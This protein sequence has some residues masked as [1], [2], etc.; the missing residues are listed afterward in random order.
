[1]KHII[2]LSKGCLIWSQRVKT[3]NNTFKFALKNTLGPPL[4]C[5]HLIKRYVSKL[6]MK[7]IVIT[8]ALVLSTMEAHANDKE[9][10]LNL[11]CQDFSWSDVE[12]L[13]EPYLDGTLNTALVMQGQSSGY[14]TS[15]AASMAMD[16]SL[17]DVI[18]RIL[19]FLVKANC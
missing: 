4:C 17:P 11:T 6:P 9:K 19:S 14:K 10:I 18:Q 12:I 2:T 3:H 15:A 13:V 5:G 16:S 1:M 8:L 7:S